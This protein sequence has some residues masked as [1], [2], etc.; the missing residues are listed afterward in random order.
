MEQDIIEFEDDFNFET[1]VT[2]SGAQIIPSGCSPWN[3]SL[4]EEGAF[5]LRNMTP[6][7]SD[8]T[9]KLNDLIEEEGLDYV[10]GLLT[11][12]DGDDERGGLL[13]ADDGM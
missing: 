11:D 7:D 10:R 12:D 3:E 2:S 5:V 6:I 4:A 8:E 13:T 9:Q 1:F